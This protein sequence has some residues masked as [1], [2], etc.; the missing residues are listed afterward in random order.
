MVD[1][2]LQKSLD[3]ELPENE[4]ETEEEVLK[5]VLEFLYKAKNPII[6]ADACSIRHRVVP[7][8]HELL[9]KLQIPAFVTP[10]G[11]GAL[12]ETNSHYGGVYIGEISLPD[13]KTA[14]E[15]SDCVLSIGALLS[16][17]N[18]VRSHPS[19]VVVGCI[20]E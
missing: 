12:N 3:L 9:N 17:F 14:V 10:M 15:N 1:E 13:V 6:L 5:T 4:K 2:R 16:D 19:L 8:T 20:D 18:T 11:K 7:E